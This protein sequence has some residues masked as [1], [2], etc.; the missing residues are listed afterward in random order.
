MGVNDR[1]QLA[2]AE[3]AMQHRLRQAAMLGGATL[4]APETVFLSH[5]T[6]LGRD[7]VVE[8]NVVFGQD[9]VVEDGA[10]I[11]AFSHI[12]GA[13]IRSGAII[14]PFARLRPGTD[15]GEGAHIGNFVEVKKSRIGRKAKANHLAYLG[16][17]SVGDG[18]N[19]GAG[20]ITCNYDGFDKHRTE[21][22]ANA[23]IGTNSSLVAP[24]EIGEG[25][26]IA[27]GSVITEDVPK[28][29]L[30][31]GRARQVVKAGWAKKL[32][33]EKSLG[34]EKG[35]GAEPSFRAKK[36]GKRTD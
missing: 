30:A 34:A 25:A 35:L 22:G 23:F 28:D 5:D 7:V 32:R 24:V 6:K 10:M 27:S 36:R 3:A 4:V 15:I 18:T 21:I 11:R 9:V 26:Y 17:A 33:A 13:Y 12:E 31:L 1:A 2:A 8:P 29:A 20:S 16:D 19:I 14:G